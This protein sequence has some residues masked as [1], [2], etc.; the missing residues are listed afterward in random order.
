MCTFTRVDYLTQF[1]ESPPADG[2]IGYIESDGI[3]GES[4]EEAVYIGD[5]IEA[6]VVIH[7]Q[8]SNW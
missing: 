1:Q 3:T 8:C 7:V 4:V 6:G 2:L 5:S